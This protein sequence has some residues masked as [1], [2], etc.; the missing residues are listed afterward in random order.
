LLKP[1]SYLLLEC[2]KFILHLGIDVALIF[3]DLPTPASVGNDKAVRLSLF[4]LK[5]HPR[6]LGF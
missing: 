3:S 2:F 1:H 5:Q 4:T 6:V